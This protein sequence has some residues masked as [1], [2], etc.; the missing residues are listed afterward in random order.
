MA[1]EDP[2]RQLPRIVY[3]IQGEQKR[4]SRKK[5]GE[6]LPPLLYPNSVLEGGR[7][8]LRFYPFYNCLLSHILWHHRLSQ[9]VVLQMFRTP[10]L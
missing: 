3:Y 10:T 1:G 8:K 6:G 7:A 2:N 5:L 4:D 9:C